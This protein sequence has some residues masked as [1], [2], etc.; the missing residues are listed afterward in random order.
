MKQTETLYCST[1]ETPAGP[2]SVAVNSAGAVVATAFGG[3]RSLGGRSRIANPVRDEA[4]T[5]K[6]RGQVT[7]YFRS[8]STAF[9]LELAPRGT[10]FQKRVWAAM[11]AIPAG[12][13][14]SYGAIARE[15]GSSARAVGQAS[16]ANPI[17]VIIPCHR[18]IGSDGS[19]TGFA[20]GE[21]TKRWLLD[22][23]GAITQT[24]L[25]LVESQARK[26]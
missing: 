13:T 20:F 22:H 6:A 12:R 24:S 9:S 15:L 4:R 11:R 18:V 26:P 10:D 8:A 16:G 19:L 23:E 5:A 7:G 1:F 25:P 21:A 14:R 17:C 3:E 2:F